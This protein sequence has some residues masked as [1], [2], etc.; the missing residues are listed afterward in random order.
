[1]DFFGFLSGFLAVFCLGGIF[2]SPAS[3]R[4]I[5]RQYTKDL[6]EFDGP[7]WFERMILLVGMAGMFSLIGILISLSHGSGQAPALGVFI[8][9]LW[10]VVVRF[11]RLRVQRASEAASKS[12]KAANSNDTPED[13]LQE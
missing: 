11:R 12:P 5:S 9:A 1:M 4:Q 10:D 2:L 13:D 3:L 8:G 7:V 6:G